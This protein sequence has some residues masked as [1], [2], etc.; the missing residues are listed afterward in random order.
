MS[1]YQKKKNKNRDISSEILSILNQK[2]ALTS[3]EI[4]QCLRTNEK[5][6]LIHLRRLLSE[7]KIQINH[8]NKY[9]LK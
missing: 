6:I 7:N 2:Y 8:Q 3:Q 4:N 9:Q 1:V 5:D